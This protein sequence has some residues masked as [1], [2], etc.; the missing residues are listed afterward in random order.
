MFTQA[1]YDKGNA[2]AFSWHIKDVHG[3]DENLTDDQAR[4]ILANF[5]EH[6]D[7]S[8]QAMWEDLRLH[9]DEFKRSKK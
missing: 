6:H 9:V 7:G 3:L 5:K 8:M 2:I 1:E 4:Q